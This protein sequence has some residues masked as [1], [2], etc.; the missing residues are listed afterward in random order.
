M[1]RNALRK[2]LVEN[3]MP[4]LAEGTNDAGEENANGKKRR[5]GLDGESS[6]DS[7]GEESGSGVKLVAYID[8]NRANSGMQKVYQ[9]HAEANATGADG[10]AGAASTPGKDS[11][12]G[13]PRALA[14]RAARMTPSTRRRAGEGRA[15]QSAVKSEIPGVRY[16]DLGGVEQ[17]LQD[18]RELI[19]YPLMHPEIYAH[20]GVE[21]PRG[22]LL[23][24]PP[25]SGKT[26]LASAVAA[27]LSARN[28]KFFR[29]SAPEVVSGMSGE[30]EATIRELFATA[31]ASAPAL[32]FIDEIDAITPKRESAQR[33][34]ERRIVAQ[35]LTCMDDLGT[36]AAPAATSQQALAAAAMAEDG[37]SLDT[38]IAP[39]A[40][41]KSVMV[42]G[43]TNRPDSLDP[44]LR[45]AGRFDREICMGVPDEKSRHRIL[46]VLTSKLRLS[47]D[48]DLAEIARRTPGMQNKL[49]CLVAS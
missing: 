16:C 39:P 11:E 8:K 13:M 14:S 41:P 23:H 5:R 29:I 22:V 28:I 25:G 45:R 12:E 6:S 19:E 2:T 15:F 9:K 43:A 37:V 21:P 36:T 33:E 42:I 49:A 4:R 38:P 31:K 44:A 35:L 18:V 26:M 7:G 47:G 40:A 30:S 20:L 17:C 10:T 46:T 24:G 32:V 3:V 27:E 48:F 34:M 1:P